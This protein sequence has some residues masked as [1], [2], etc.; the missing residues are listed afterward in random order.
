MKLKYWIWTFLTL[1]VLFTPIIT[2]CDSGSSGG[3]DEDIP[4]GILYLAGDV[5]ETL[6]LVF[7][8]ASDP[9]SG[10]YPAGMTVANGASE[11]EYAITLENYSPED[12]DA[13]V[14]GSAVIEITDTDPYGVSITGAINLA[15]ADYSRAT[16]DA[17]AS[18][19]EGESPTTDNPASLTGSFVVDG[20]SYAV[21]DIMAAL[22]ELEE[23]EPDPLEPPDVPPVTPPAAD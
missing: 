18:W 6:S 22:K 2:A 4:N 13:V 16:L 3:D 10:S 19:D 17:D 14:N 21:S 5:F 7:R 15:D 1:A 23:D 9:A 8:Q 11:G 20:T 12:S